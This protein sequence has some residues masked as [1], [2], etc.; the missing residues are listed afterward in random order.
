MKVL[1]PKSSFHNKGLINYL[2]YFLSVRLCGGL[3]AIGG[4]SA[5]APEGAC[6]LQ[7][8]A[9]SFGACLPL[10]QGCFIF[11]FFKI[12]LICAIWFSVINA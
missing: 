1:Y 2:L 3:S 5:V 12:I 4:L 8:E 7:S 9:A 6:S 10:E 11:I